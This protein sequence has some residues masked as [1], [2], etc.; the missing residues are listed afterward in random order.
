MNA[1]AYQIINQMLIYDLLRHSDDLR[2]KNEKL[3]PVIFSKSSLCVEL[4]GIKTI[5]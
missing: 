2:L 1:Y 5:S 4:V 3:E